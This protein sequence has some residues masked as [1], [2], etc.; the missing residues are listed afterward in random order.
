M[1]V[2][3]IYLQSSPIDIVH[4]SLFHIIGRRVQNNLLLGFALVHVE[5]FGK[6][7]EMLADLALLGSVISSEQK[8]K[9]NFQGIKEIER[10][11]L[12]IHFLF[13]NF[14]IKF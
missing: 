12:T 1:K 14:D 6:S 3:L 10:W 7:G 2:N 4:I 5:K 9:I 11:Q 8:I 13:I